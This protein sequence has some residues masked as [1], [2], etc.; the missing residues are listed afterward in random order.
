[1]YFLDRQIHL[2]AVVG[3]GRP[4][5]ILDMVQNFRHDSGT[6]YG[7]ES[8]LG[9]RWSRRSKNMVTVRTI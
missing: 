4:V 2:V 3:S 8:A 5:K 6:T 1:M 7:R 9:N